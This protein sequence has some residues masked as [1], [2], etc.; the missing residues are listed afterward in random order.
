MSVFKNLLLMSATLSLGA[1]AY[2]IEDAIQDVQFLTPGAQNAECDVF[3]DGLRFRVS[4]PETINLPK[5]YQDLVVDCKA[6]GNRRKKI[7]IKPQ[8]SE[9]S[10]L[11]L[12]TAGV[13]YVWDHV[14]GAMYKYPLVVEV[15][16][17]DTPVTE[18]PLPAQNNPDIRQPEDYPLEEFKPGSPILNED[19]YKQQTQ[20]LR[21]G[22]G[23]YANER[24][25]QQDSFYEPSGSLSG[26]GS[27]TKVIEDTTSPSGA[28]PT[29]LIPGE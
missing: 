26:K 14:S 6:P 4:P 28:V 20:I 27:F 21:R 16:F 13:G 2:A 9:T 12:A 29:P 17:T 25:V 1:C 23:A 15:N 10:H 5:G 19:R 7:Y 22:E 18:M 8:I 3:V 24:A 11:N